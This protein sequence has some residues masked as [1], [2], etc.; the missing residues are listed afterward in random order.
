MVHGIRRLPASMQA[1][2]RK[3]H[4]RAPVSMAI[5]D[6]RTIVEVGSVTLVRGLA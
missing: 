1:R 2:A 4:A 3:L 5:E 6:R